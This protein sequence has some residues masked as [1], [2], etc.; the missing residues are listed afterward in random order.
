[1]LSIWHRNWLFWVIWHV[2]SLA[3]ILL[4]TTSPRKSLLTKANW[5]KH[6]GVSG[7]RQDINICQSV[8]PA[9]SRGLCTLHRSNTRHADEDAGVS[10]SD[11]RASAKMW[12]FSRVS[13]ALACLPTP[14]RDMFETGDSHS[15]DRVPTREQILPACALHTYVSHDS[16][17]T[18][19]V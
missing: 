8:S 15:G 13:T 1:M 17:S 18:Y 9:S 6:L 5:L 4:F 12:R 14:R 2:C 19:M 3:K 7:V 11:W 10:R 16:H